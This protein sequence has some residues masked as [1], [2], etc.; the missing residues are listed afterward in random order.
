MLPILAVLEY[1]L[2]CGHDNEVSR[3]YAWYVQGRADLLFCSS[4]LT[5]VIPLDVGYVVEIFFLPKLFH[6]LDLACN[7]R[8]LHRSYENISLWGI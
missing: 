6:S 8:P 3:P 4:N 1:I 7:S 2:L 5:E